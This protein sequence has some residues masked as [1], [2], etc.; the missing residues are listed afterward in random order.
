MVGL[1]LV[2]VRFNWF[3]LVSI[4]LFSL[5]RLYFMCWFELFLF[6]S[7]FFFLRFFAEWTLL[8]CAF[9]CAMRSAE[10]EHKIAVDEDPNVV[11]A[12]E[13]KRHWRKVDKL[14]RDFGRKVERVDLCAS[15]VKKSREQSWL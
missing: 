2:F 6:F 1:V 5:Y 14:G 10:I 7:F 3:Q 4:G 9:D 11:V 12:K 13:G 15:G 8:T